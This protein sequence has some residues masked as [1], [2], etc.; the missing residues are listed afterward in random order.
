[1]PAL[2][3]TASAIAGDYTPRVC[4]SRTNTDRHLDGAPLRD[5]GS[6]L[7]RSRLA[8]CERSQ[9]KD[10]TDFGETGRTAYLQVSGSPA[11][12][13]D[14]NPRRLAGQRN[15]WRLLQR[16]EVAAANLLVNVAKEFHASAAFRE[17]PGNF[18]VPYLPV[19]FQQPGEECLTLAR[20]KLSDRCLNFL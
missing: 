17:V 7:R 4:Q 8:L 10:E 15:G 1:M 11:V 9:A 18:L 19:G 13:G 16:I 3:V 2:L 6:R 20:G 5:S 14:S 12:A